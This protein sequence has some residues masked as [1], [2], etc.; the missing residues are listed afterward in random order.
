MKYDKQTSFI[1]ELP[2]VRREKLEFYGNHWTLTDKKSNVLFE[3]YL[4]IKVN[5]KQL[6]CTYNTN[7]EGLSI[8]C[9]G[10]RSYPESRCN[11][12]LIYN[13]SKADDLVSVQY[14]HTKVSLNPEYYI[15]ECTA[16]MP[17]SNIRTGLYEFYVVISPNTTTLQC[18]DCGKTA[19]KVN[20]EKPD[21]VLGNCSMRVLEGTR[22]DCPCSR[23]D[24]SDIATRIVW[25][26]ERML[27][28]QDTDTSV[29]TSKVTSNA[30]TY[31]CSAVNAFGWRINKTYKPDIIYQ[32]YLENPGCP[33]DRPHLCL[34]HRI[35]YGNDEFCVEGKV[36]SC[37]PIDVEK[38]ELSSWC[39]TKGQFNESLMR[40]RACH[41]AC[42]ARFGSEI[43][44]RDP[45]ILNINDLYASVYILSSVFSIVVLGLIAWILRKRLKRF[46]YKLYSIVWKNSA[47]GNQNTREH[48]WNQTNLISCSEYKQ[49]P[50]ECL[51]TLEINDPDIIEKIQAYIDLY[52]SLTVRLVVK[53]KSQ[54]L[55]GNFYGS[56]LVVNVIKVKSTDIQCKCPNSQPHS[57]WCVYVST[58]VKVVSNEEEAR[59]TTAELFYDDESKAGVKEL[60]GVGI[61][62]F[63]KNE[64]NIIQCVSCDKDL[65]TQLKSALYKLKK[66]V[67]TINYRNN[68]VVIVSHP[69][70]K[71][72]HM[73]IGSYTETA[74]TDDPIFTLSRL[75]YNTPSC[76]GMEG[77]AVLIL[78][79][80]FKER[81][82]KLITADFIVH[83]GVNQV[84]DNFSC[85][86]PMETDS[87]DMDAYKD[88]FTV[89]FEAHIDETADTSAA[90]DKDHDHKMFTPLSKFSFEELG[91][92]NVY[93]Y[94]T[95]LAELTCKI[96][97]DFT[98]SARPEFIEGTNSPYPVG[99]RKGTASMRSGTGVVLSVIKI[100]DGGASP[101]PCPACNQLDWPFKKF[102]F[103]YVRTAKHIVF[104]DSEVVKS[105]IRL[106]FDNDLSSEMLISGG[107]IVESDMKFGTS[108]VQYVTHD[109]RITH[110]SNSL[111]N[112]YKLEQT[113]KAQLASKKDQSLAI[114]VSHLH[115]WP[116]HISTGHW[117]ERE[118]TIS[119]S[120]T[121]V[122]YTYT[123][124]TCPG[125]S[126]APVF[127]PG[128]GVQRVFK[129]LCLPH[130][131]KETGK[132]GRGVS[133]LGVKS[134]R[135]VKRKSE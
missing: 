38:S 108:L 51:K 91:E 94:I 135:V 53:N 66:I 112:L 78:N 73:S 47:A 115:G 104:D 64:S 24:K 87:A 43:I 44:K 99:N 79:E 95:N 11:F 37:F 110:I 98:S 20:I 28:Q 3:T 131:H 41:G 122:R 114:I 83:C 120:G 123:T 109:T 7:T 82:L 36:E 27:L 67:K 107:R 23:V 49:D 55:N 132:D 92:L 93:E 100:K 102:Y 116:K 54:S 25:Y 127:I 119:K 48:Q 6:N 19:V 121:Y 29:L 39:E 76:E 113:I 2:S 10:S 101:C 35:C 86:V 13:G 56:G 111:R 1:V 26:Q 105:T 16:T 81:F 129:N 103:V 14:N 63:T 69:Y 32:S 65:C 68:A 60:L 128:E 12:S 88:H 8:D 133:C 126:G 124:A 18:D 21:I 97:V 45:V 84:R 50:K 74:T 9:I 15:T 96:D 57:S 52:I 106:K 130:V 4:L 31:T 118:L 85:Y 34:P 77:A 62:Q 30:Q 59:S 90:C 117:L 134:F 33:N 61:Y 17:I 46:G 58:S 89:N 40:S 72:K 5:P 75:S 22:V 125:S 80:T 70:G 42:A 71:H